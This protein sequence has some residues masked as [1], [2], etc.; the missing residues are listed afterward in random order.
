VRVGNHA[1]GDGRLAV[2][3]SAPF[4]RH[5][6]QLVQVARRPPSLP[7]LQAE[8]DGRAAAISAAS[9]RLYCEA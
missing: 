8:F 4:V 5:S 1:E 3:G 6:F 9:L 2:G 7:A